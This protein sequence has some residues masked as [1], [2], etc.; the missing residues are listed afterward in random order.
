MICVCLNRFFFFKCTKFHFAAGHLVQISSKWA[1]RKIWA[2]TEDFLHCF[3]FLTDYQRKAEHQYFI[4]CHCCL[5]WRRQT[6]NIWALLSVNL[7]WRSLVSF[8]NNNLCQLGRILSRGKEMIKWNVLLIVQLEQRYFCLQAPT[9]GRHDTHIKYRTRLAGCKQTR[10]FFRQRNSNKFHFDNDQKQ[11]SGKGNLPL[12][13][14]DSEDL[15]IWGGKV[16][17]SGF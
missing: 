16:F 7:W 14:A 2:V 4:W 10:V 3:S 15:V 13:E 5:C 12:R 9:V 17:F 6:N 1:T 8:I 11:R